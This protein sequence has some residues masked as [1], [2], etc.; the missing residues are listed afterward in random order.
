MKTQGKN[1]CFEQTIF[2]EELAEKMYMDGKND[3]EISKDV[4]VTKQVIKDWRERNDMPGNMGLFSWQTKIK[5]SEF[6]K[7]PEKYRNPRLRVG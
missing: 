4:G 6:R 2:N 7:I 3:P 1:G 5:P